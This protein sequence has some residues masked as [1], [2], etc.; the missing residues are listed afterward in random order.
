MG[1]SLLDDLNHDGASDL[2]MHDDGVAGDVL[3]GD[4][5]YSG[6]RLSTPCKPISR[7]I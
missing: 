6:N 4:G 2:V 7:A 5:V 3:A 1:S